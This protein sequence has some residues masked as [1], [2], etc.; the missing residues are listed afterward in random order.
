M[1]TP[2]CMKVSVLLDSKRNPCLRTPTMFVL[3]KRII[4]WADIRSFTLFICGDY[5]STMNTSSALFLSGSGSIMATVVVVVVVGSL[6]EGNGTMTTGTTLGGISSG[7]K[8]RRISLSGQHH[9]HDS[10]ERGV[11]VP[12]TP[13]DH[14]LH[15]V[16]T[17]PEDLGHLFAAHAVQV[18]VSDSQDVVPAMQAAVL[19]EKKI[20]Y[21]RGGNVAAIG[22]DFCRVIA[23][24]LDRL[25]QGQDLVEQGA[26]EHRFEQAELLL[27][28][29]LPPLLQFGLETLHRLQG[30]LCICKP[31]HI[32]VTA[33]A[34]LKE[35]MQGD[36]VD[37]TKLLICRLTLKN[38]RSAPG[39]RLSDLIWSRWRTE[40]TRERCGTR[41]SQ[42]CLDADKLSVKQPTNIGKKT[43][44]FGLP[45]LRLSASTGRDVAPAQTDALCHT[46]ITWDRMQNT[47]DI[48][49]LCDTLIV[50]LDL[51]FKPIESIAR[52]AIR[53]VESTTAKRDLGEMTACGTCG[54]YLRLLFL[55]RQTVTRNT[56]T[57]LG[58]TRCRLR[59]SFQYIIETWLDEEH[60]DGP[61]TAHFISR[62]GRSVCAAFGKICRKKKRGRIEEEDVENGECQAVGVLLWAFYPAAIWRHFGRHLAPE[63]QDLWS[64]RK[65]GA[66]EGAVP[67]TK[68]PIRAFAIKRLNSTGTFGSGR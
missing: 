58:W 21:V 16:A 8:P 17:L 39:L 6:V 65:C 24:M 56:L 10:R 22:L 45:A 43:T 53:R 46:G 37:R 40:L 35:W 30:T 18:G 54:C 13:G 47:R 11:F 19:R 63:Q 34:R 29:H 20:R 28:G 27:S 59:D 55:L 2:N 25:L 9:R 50:L 44:W 5:K 1:D 4:C 48:V 68:H 26:L 42:H 32:S 3:C 57:S 52:R 14:Q 41:G 38:A 12:R 60:Q 23:E 7:L 67:S 64:C 33:T 61:A 62:K 36:V 15:P 49:F 31:S 66:V 51:F